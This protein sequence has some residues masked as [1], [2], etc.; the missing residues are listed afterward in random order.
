[1][2]LAEYAEDRFIYLLELEALV[3]GVGVAAAYGLLSCTSVKV[4][5]AW[6]LE[7]LEV[8]CFL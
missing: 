2:K 4:E 5:T 6:F 7:V 3:A 8:L 1:M